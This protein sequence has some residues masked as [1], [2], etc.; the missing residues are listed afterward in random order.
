MSANPR[1]LPTCT[2]SVFSGC[3]PSAKPASNNTLG[4]GCPA[5]LP[6]V[7]FSPRPH[8]ESFSRASSSGEKSRPLQQERC[9]FG[10]HFPSHAG[11][12][13]SSD[14]VQGA[15][16]VAIVSA[17]LFLRP[18]EAPFFLRLFRVA[19]EAAVVPRIKAASVATLQGSMIEL[20]TRSAH[21]I[22]MVLSRRP[23]GSLEDLG[24]TKPAWPRFQI[25]TERFMGRQ[26]GF[27]RLATLSAREHLAGTRP[28]VGS[29]NKRPQLP[30][31]GRFF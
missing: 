25:R 10:F 2:K 9:I 18:L 3:L 22:C 19:T 16:F 21:R 20:S 31:W 14:L 28:S 29:S 15:A 7:C 5:S 4:L 23:R 30:S 26:L 13:K 27:L 17:L 24:S 12:E 6:S 11:G 1:T 8:S